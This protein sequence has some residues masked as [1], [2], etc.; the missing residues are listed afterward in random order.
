MYLAHVADGQ[1]DDHRDPDEYPEQKQQADA[2]QDRELGDEERGDERDEQGA[3][4]DERGEPEPDQ[5]VRVN[6]GHAPSWGRAIISYA[7]VSMILS[8]F[9]GETSPFLISSLV[10]VLEMN[11]R[12]S[13]RFA[14]LWMN[15]FRIHFFRPHF[16][17][18]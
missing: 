10:S 11:S 1:R 3:G 9:K 6:F 14:A 18:L 13:C 12:S 15:M 16:C 17:I 5:G 2:P 4:E 7:G 8:S